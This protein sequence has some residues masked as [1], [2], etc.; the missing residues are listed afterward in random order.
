MTN[1]RTMFCFFFFR[2]QLVFCAD[3]LETKMFYF[4]TYC[5]WVILNGGVQ[6]GPL[7]RGSRASEGTTQVP[8]KWLEWWAAE[9]VMLKE[10][11][12]GELEGGGWRW[13]A[14]THREIKWHCPH[15]LNMGKLRLQGV[16]NTAMTW[17]CLH[18]GLVLKG[19]QREMATPS[20]CLLANLECRQDQSM[21]PA[22]RAGRD[23]SPWAAPKSLGN[24]SSRATHM[25]YVTKQL[26]AR[27]V[28]QEWEA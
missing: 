28:F 20:L 11:Q 26:V 8:S 6:R 16:G 21:P 19:Y 25:I 17:S 3:D 23:W 2:Y 13:Y 24:R 15:L 10:L 14:W 4:L 1:G 12:K 18:P 27:H 22:L 5:P 7:R 9:K